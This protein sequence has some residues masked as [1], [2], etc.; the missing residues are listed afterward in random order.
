ML[1]VMLLTTLTASVTQSCLFN[2]ASKK[3]LK[4]DDQI[5]Y[6]N[7]FLSAV[8]FLL[9]GIMLL[10]SQKLS[11]FTVLLGI[12]FGALTAMRNAYNMQ[13]L[14]NGPMNITLLITTSSTLIPTLSGVFFGE[15]FSFTKLGIVFILIGFIYISLEQKDNSG[16]NKT[17]FAYALLTF[18]SQGA[19]G[20]LQKVHQ[21][22]VHKEEVSGFL[23]VAFIFS[24]IIN[25]IRIKEIKEVH[26]PR[27]TIA[28]ATICGVCTFSVNYL[29]LKLAGLLPTQIFFP[30]VNG[31]S[32]VLSQIM[33]VVL[34]KETLSTKQFIGLAGG[35]CS[36]IAICIIP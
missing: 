9:F 3:E 28:Y 15:Q 1:I 31:G 27:K 19:V 7:S 32:M 23:F 35:I 14:A 8:C 20:V 12:L 33:A 6:Y 22:S 18:L 5:F 36:L 25:R 29:N 16:I 17:W 30:L 10:I 2:V 34:F 26:I 13:A 21:V 11:V 4:T 24:F